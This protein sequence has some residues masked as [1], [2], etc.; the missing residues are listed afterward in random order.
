MSNI[1]AKSR[2]LNSSSKAFAES[3]EQY[4]CE[5]SRFPLMAQLPWEKVL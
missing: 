3:F 1:S 5:L 2:I 4:A